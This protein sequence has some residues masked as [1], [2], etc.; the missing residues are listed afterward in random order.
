MNEK[1]SERA[2]TQSKR[3]C[4]RDGAYDVTNVYDDAGDNL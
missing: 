3:A 2:H 4:E 1:A